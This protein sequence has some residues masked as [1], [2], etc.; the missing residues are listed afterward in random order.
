MATMFTFQFNYCSLQIIIQYKINIRVYMF[1]FT[2]L[3]LSILHRKMDKKDLPSIVFKSLRL[4]NL[5]ECWL[6]TWSASGKEACWYSKDLGRLYNLRGTR[7]SVIVRGQTWPWVV[8]KQGLKKLSKKKSC[9]FLCYGN[10]K[11]F[12]DRVLEYCSWVVK[13]IELG[14]G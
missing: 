1:N 9:L 13:K 10:C 2:E 14:I 12:K 5:D 8:K 11:D 7:M 4:F 3:P 6:K